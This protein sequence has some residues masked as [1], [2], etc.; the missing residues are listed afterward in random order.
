M[1]QKEKNWILKNLKQIFVIDIVE[2]TDEQIENALEFLYALGDYVGF[3]L[4]KEEQ[5]YLKELEKKNEM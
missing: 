4:N 2:D 3:D 1:N 5:K